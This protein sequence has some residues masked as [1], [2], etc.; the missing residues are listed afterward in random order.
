M[1]EVGQVLNLS[2]EVEI[3]GCE[4]VRGARATRTQISVLS[5]EIDLGEYVDVW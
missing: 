2:V 4:S 5:N 1:F 3:E